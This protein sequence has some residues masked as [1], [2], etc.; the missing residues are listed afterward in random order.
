LNLND[1][2]AELNRRIVVRLPGL[3]SRLPVQ[4]AGTLLP[5]FDAGKIQ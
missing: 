2:L 3:N 1:F 5:V 4:L